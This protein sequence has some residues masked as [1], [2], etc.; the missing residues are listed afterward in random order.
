MAVWYTSSNNHRPDKA[1]LPTQS[2][3]LRAPRRTFLPLLRQNFILKQ[4]NR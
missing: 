4:L 2:T 1:A 3:N